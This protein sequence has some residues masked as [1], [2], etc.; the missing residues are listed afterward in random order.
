MTDP[1]TN[2]KYEEIT[3]AARKSM[4]FRP[5]SA[6]FARDLVSDKKKALDCLERVWPNSLPTDQAKAVLAY[7]AEVRRL[8][9]R[10]END[11]WPRLARH[12]PCGCVICECPGDIKCYGCG[13]KNCQTHPPGEI[14]NPVYEQHPLVARVREQD[15]EIARLKEEF[16]HNEKAEPYIDIVFDG[17]PAHESGR[18]VEVENKDG[19]SVSV[20]HWIER[21]GGYWALRIVLNH[22]TNW[23]FDLQGFIKELEQIKE[24]QRQEI[25]KLHARLAAFDNA[26]KGELAREPPPPL[27]YWGSH[28]ER[29]LVDLRQWGRDLARRC[30]AAEARVKEVERATATLD[31]VDTMISHRKNQEL[32]ALRVTL[33]NIR[34]LVGEPAPDAPTIALADPAPGLEKGGDQP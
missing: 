17:P 14:P 31:E 2:A 28:V 15:T 21:D 3:D 22:H 25:G 26:L 4:G 18:F 32:A 30:V 23:I 29:H 19:K 27:E 10:L 24:H 7:I 11:Q 13:A 6:P 16:S 12:Q 9:A 20:G 33:A 1:N 34:A 8:R 5:S